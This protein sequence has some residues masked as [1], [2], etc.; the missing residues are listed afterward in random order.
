MHTNDILESKGRRLDLNMCVGCCWV[1]FSLGFGVLPIV[2]THLPNQHST[3]LYLGLAEKSG[4][5]W[6]YIKVNYSKIEVLPL[7]NEI[8]Q[9][10]HERSHLQGRKLDSTTE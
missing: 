6:S 8:R 2:Y 9:G 4:S 7:L 3:L 5:N 10:N 1:F